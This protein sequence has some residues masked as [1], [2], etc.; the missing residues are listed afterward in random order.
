MGLTFITTPPQPSNSQ[1]SIQGIRGSHYSGK[2]GRDRPLSP[3]PSVCVQVRNRLT[4]RAGPTA[5][6][7]AH[8]DRSGCCMP[9]ANALNYM[10]R[11]TGT[12]Y[13]PRRFGRRRAPGAEAGSEG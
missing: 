5:A 2:A 7:Q 1:P 9:A 3:A 4:L 12:T 11:Q 6:W 10:L 8:N 13:R